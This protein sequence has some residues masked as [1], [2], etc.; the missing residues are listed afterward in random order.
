MSSEKKQQFNIY[1]PP[2]LIRQVKHAAVDAGESLSDFVAEALAAYV[3]RQRGETQ[4][5]SLPQ[6]TPRAE[7]AAQQARLTL[8]TIVYVRNTDAVMPFY[9]ALGMKP[10]AI[11]RRR[12]WIELQLGDAILGLHQSDQPSSQFVRSR[13]VELSLNSHE[14]LETFLERLAAAGFTT[15][16]PILDETFGRYVMIEAPDGFLIQVNEEDPDLFT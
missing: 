11:E 5:I 6:A 12:G 14:P 3:Q 1:L 4:A 2:E 8:M 10:I 7:G 15:D 9:Q 16:H 13:S